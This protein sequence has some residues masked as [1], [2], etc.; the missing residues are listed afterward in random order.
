MTLILN[1]DIIATLVFN[2]CMLMYL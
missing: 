2:K 1:I